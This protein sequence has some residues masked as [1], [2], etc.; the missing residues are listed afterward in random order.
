MRET[1][2]RESGDAPS[3]ALPLSIPFNRPTLVGRE[4][5]YMLDALH[6]GHIAGDGYYSKKC[7]A[8]LAEAH[9][10]QKAL[11]TTSCTH[12]LEIAA[13][14]LEF[15]PG[16]EVIVPSFTFVSTVNAFVIC[17]ARPVFIDV[18]PDTLNLDEQQLE[19]LITPATRA[20]VPVHY[21]GI[22]CEMDAIVATTRQRDIA[23]VE[24]NAH[25]LFGRYRGRM[26]GTFG[27]ISTLSFHET[28]NFICGEGGAL[29]L[30]DERFVQRAEIIREK[31]TN[32]SQFFRGQVDKYT[33]VDIG[34]SYLPSDLLAAFLYAQL[35]QRETVL[36]RR[37]QVF[38]RYL[39][40]LA[41]WANE[42]GVTLPTIPLECTPSYHMFY[43]LAPSLE[44]RTALIDHLRVRGIS[45]VFHYQPLHVSP[46]GRRL[47]GEPGQCP[48]SE[49]VA[50][51]L[52]RLPFHNDLS[53]AAQDT[54]IE[55]IETFR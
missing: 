17:G 46:M 22:G 47:G 6:R 11:L 44:Y 18:R 55:A 1:A 53:A 27:P 9:G 7:H 16:D 5:E 36:A 33:W 15:A 19:A 21:A 51:R 24:D 42:E 3:T 25:G 37:R 32:R 29:I 39:S 41:A 28:K 31:G 23:I 26:L 34:S 54:V 43:M 12:A 13:R 14:L 30:N 20:V 38:E 40:G 10:A 50:D 52:L 49:D 35:E 8:L 2:R 4:R 48:V 45:A